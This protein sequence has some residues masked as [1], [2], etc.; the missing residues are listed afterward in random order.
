MKVHVQK[1]TAMLLAV[2]LCLSIPAFA[3]GYVYSPDPSLAVA[4]DVKVT[5]YFSSEFGLTVTLV[6]S[7]LNFPHVGKCSSDEFKQCM[8][9][10]SKGGFYTATGVE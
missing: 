7:R 5:G 4:F 6:S 3:A 2:S 8:D 9:Y 1:L 10:Y